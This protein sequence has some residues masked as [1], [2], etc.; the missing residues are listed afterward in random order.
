VTGPGARAVLVFLAVT[1]CAS[2]SPSQLEPRR[3]GQN[4]L[5]QA[6]FADGRLW[7]L[8]DGGELS[9][10]AEGGAAHGETPLPE[11]A[12][13]L[14]ARGGHLEALTCAEGG[15]A[16]WTLRR[17]ASAGWSTV[18]TVATEGDLLAAIDCAQDAT[19]LLTSRR[20]VTVSDSKQAEMTLPSDLRGRDITTMYTTANY[21]YVG[22]DKGEWGGGLRRIDR[23]TGRVAVVE[24]NPSGA[25]CGGPLNTACDPVHA[26][27]P[28]PWTPGCVVAAVGQEHLTPDG[29]IV[30]ICGDR[31][32]EIFSKPYEPPPGRK[33][34]GIREPFGTVTFHG[35]AN[36]G[37]ALW[38]IG[39][40]GVYRIR[41]PDDAARVELPAF[42]SI[43]GIDV[44]FD[45]PGV[46][47]IF[48][49]S[50]RL[51]TIAGVPLVVAR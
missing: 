28:A 44:S 7:M 10:I 50:R 41:G 30:E 37:D 1:S 23:R 8:S 45:V 24:S 43:G 18:A 49:G 29:R 14:C 51:P 13:A 3:P 20:L 6:L 15:C 39:S 21:V 38:A 36:A 5:M 33:R 40:D 42:K 2:V 46:V 27:A 12:L 47:M 48:T 9:S 11:P 35:L 19:T 32:R 34:H 26:I 31:V 17:W 22:L 25:L 16:T 4:F